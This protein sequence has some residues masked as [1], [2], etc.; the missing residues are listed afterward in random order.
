MPRNISFALTI[1]QF[2]ARTKTV[3]RRLGW[4]TLKVGDVL[5]GCAKCMGLKPGERLQRLGLIRVVNLRVEP[6]ESIDAADVVREGFPDWS[7]AQFITF[8]LGSMGGAPD[9]PVTRIAFEYV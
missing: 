8:F 5:C 6:L 2:R 4:R 3:T 9:Q 1:P 7:P